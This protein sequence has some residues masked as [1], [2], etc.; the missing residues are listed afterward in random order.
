MCVENT[1]FNAR[2]PKSIRIPTVDEESVQRICEHVDSLIIAWRLDPDLSS[3]PNYS[4]NILDDSIKTWWVSSFRSD[5]YVLTDT[6]I[7]SLVG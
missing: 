6:D 2:L 5:L 4:Y 1:K 7:E 3:N